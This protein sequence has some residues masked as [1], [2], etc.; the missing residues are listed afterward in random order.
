MN[1]ARVG[2]IAEQIRG[3]T[4]SKGEAT[5][6]PG[7]DSVALLRAGNITDSGIDLS[8][9]T[10]VPRSRVSERQ[11][12]MQD[13]VL[14]AASSGSLSVVGKSARVTSPLE[15]TFGAFCKVLRPRTGVHPGYF[16]H[17]FRTPEYRRY[18][19]SVAAGANINN[20]RADDLDRIELPL[21]PLPEQRRIAAILDEADA[22]RT[23]V[24]T[25]LSQ[26]SEFA[27]VEQGR[28]FTSS[29]RTHTL[30][31]LLA[32]IESGVSPVC[33]SRPAGDDE[34]GVLK[35]GAITTGEYCPG[36]NKAI[37]TGYAPK[38][39]LAVQA[40]DVLLSRKNTLDHVGASVYVTRT[41]RR[42]LLP[43]L[44]FRLVPHNPSIGRALQAFLSLPAT[45]RELS[46]LAGG[47]ASS[48]ANISKARL[49]TLRVPSFAPPMVARIDALAAATEALRSRAL[50]QATELDELFAA[51]Q[52]RAFRG[53]L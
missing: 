16:A 29:A 7:P 1:T 48:M 25:R 3:V 9:L 37:R 22:L 45:R 24:T 15:A 32:R 20:L 2:D 31:D 26:V 53:K 51:L 28:V 46:G 11:Q 36:E 41:P 42:R 19:S 12:I 27:R 6:E 13:D 50:Q 40:G 49:M 8:D 43:D 47:S 14:I 35:L 30:A 34:W 52:D 21:P 4:Y 5:A 17:Y 23:A 33:E 18:I 38:E 10:Y 39:A 44:V